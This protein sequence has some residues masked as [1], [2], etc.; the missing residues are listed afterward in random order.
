MLA[1]TNAFL[2]ASL[3]WLGF[4]TTTPSSPLR[5]LDY[6]C[7]PGTMTAALWGQGAAFTGLDIS[8]NMVAE[9]NSR[10]EGEEFAGK[11]S[12]AKGLVGNLLGETVD[13]GVV[14]PDVKLDGGFDLVV[15]GYGFH[16]FPKPAL[17]AERLSRCLKPGGW[18]VIVDLAPH[19][20]DGGVK[21]GTVHHGFGE[22]EVRG[23]FEGV[24]L[25]EVG[26]RDM[27]GG[28]EM[29]VGEGGKMVQRGV[30]VARGRKQQVRDEL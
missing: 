24:G 28:I 8:E 10:F 30:F 25:R 13:L 12:T 23:L 21:A 19:E 22:K 26:V 2:S 18:L 5:I 6:A 9:Y 29:G 16:H 1:K 14:I 27:E 7:G 3:S 20:P 11:G 15:V 4:P 17:A